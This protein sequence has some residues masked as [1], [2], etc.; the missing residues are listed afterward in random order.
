[1]KKSVIKFIL[2]ILTGL[3]LISSVYASTPQISNLLRYRSIVFKDSFSTSYTPSSSPLTNFYNNWNYQGKYDYL[4]GLPR[5]NNSFYAL[6]GSVG[7][8][9]QINRNKENYNLNR[10]IDISYSFYHGYPTGN[11]LHEVSIGG[12]NTFLPDY[13]YNYP[14]MST[15][16]YGGLC[17]WGY[18]HY[19]SDITL[20]IAN[21]KT[22]IAIIGTY[23]RGTTWYVFLK[24]RRNT[25]YY[26]VNSTGATPTSYSSVT[27]TDRT[28]SSNSLIMMVSNYNDP[29]NGAQPV[30]LDN[31]KVTLY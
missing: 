14:S 2:L 4:T 23:A 1:M 8:V 29:D 25:L 22:N 27:I 31:L 20:K 10:A 12:D 30:Y 9:G 17:I 18:Q 19:G 28:V 3:F 21:N 5:I 24:L 15:P 16:N 13:L 7:S 11:S 26:A 6:G